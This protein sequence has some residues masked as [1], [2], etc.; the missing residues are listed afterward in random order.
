MQ[1]N[2]QSLRQQRRAITASEREQSARKILHQMQKISS[3][4]DGQKI[5]LYLENDGEISPKHIHN[6]LKKQGIG[7]YLPILVGKSLKFAKL[8]NKFKKNKFGIDEPVATKVL[9]AEQ[10]DVI[11]IPLVGFDKNKNRIGMGSGFYDRT[12]SFKKNQTNYSNPK[13]YGLAFD[14]Q[15]VDKIDVQPWDIKLYAIITP[16]STY[17]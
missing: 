5:A 8:G 2:R 13:L 16:T 17:F 9:N 12:L 6:F 14:C 7:I 3:I 4:Q 10:L 11:F 15:K 1:A